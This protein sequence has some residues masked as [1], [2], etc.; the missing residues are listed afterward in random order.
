MPEEDAQSNRSPGFEPTAPIW[1]RDPRFD[2]GQDLSNSFDDNTFYDD[3]VPMIAGEGVPRP[4]SVF[5][6]DGTNTLYTVFLIV[7]AALGA[8]L[9]NFP[10]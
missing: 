8:G 7:N 2:H 6:P 3:D 5:N 9:L 1:D 4:H 10:M